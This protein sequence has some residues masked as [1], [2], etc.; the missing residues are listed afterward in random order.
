MSDTLCMILRYSA[1]LRPSRRIRSLDPGPLL[2]RYSGGEGL[3]MRGLSTVK[4]TPHPRPLSPEY[5]GEGSQDFNR[6]AASL[7]FSYSI[8]S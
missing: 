1:L 8:Y 5:R 7:G 2:P 6:E 4:S 3:G